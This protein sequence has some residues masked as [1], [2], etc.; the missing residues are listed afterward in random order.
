M[1]EAQ[2]FSNDTGPRACIHL[3]RS[4]EAFDAKLAQK[5]GSSVFIEI[6]LSRNTKLVIVPISGMVTCKPK[7]KKNSGL[8]IG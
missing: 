6:P 8:T 4:Y 1:E 7:E 3:T 2:I 5:P